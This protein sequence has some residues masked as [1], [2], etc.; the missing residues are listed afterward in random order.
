VQL[1]WD[2]TYEC[3]D[4]LIDEQHRQL[5][6]LGNAVLDEAMSGAPTAAVRERLS[7][8]LS[9]VV[10][11]FAE[12]E[13][14]LERIGFA[15]RVL[16]RSLH[17]ALVDEALRLESQ[18]EEDRVGVQELLGF[19]VVRVVQEHLLGADTLFFPAV[20]ASVAGRTEGPGAPH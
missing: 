8:L 12:E 9:H 7:T 4:A 2:P 5:F 17:R 16:H 18:L 15:D 20:A 19:L 14:L 6:A 1:V 3:G 13:E 11:H 10:A